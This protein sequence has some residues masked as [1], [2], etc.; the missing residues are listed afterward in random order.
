MLR[1][2]LN[3]QRKQTCGLMPTG[4]L[5]KEHKLNQKKISSLKIIF[6]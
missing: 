6:A 5:I 1:N 3:Q 2:R 4:R